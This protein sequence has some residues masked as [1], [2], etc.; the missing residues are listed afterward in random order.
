MQDSTASVSANGRISVARLTI[1]LGGTVDV[2][3][4]GGAPV[5]G[6]PLVGLYR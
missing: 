2:N 5:A 3:A 1:A 6:P 4:A